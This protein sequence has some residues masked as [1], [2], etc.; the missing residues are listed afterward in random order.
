MKDDTAGI[1]FVI[2]FVSLILIIVVVSLISNHF[3]GGQMNILRNDSPI[4]KVNMEI[5]GPSDKS[6]DC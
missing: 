6:K 2:G 4:V 5:V 3:Y 1:V